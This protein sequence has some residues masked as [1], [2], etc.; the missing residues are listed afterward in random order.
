MPQHPNP[1]RSR[2]LLRPWLG[3]G[4]GDDETRAA[5]ALPS[6]AG[7]SSGTSAADSHFTT[8]SARAPL[9][10]VLIEER[11][12]TRLRGGDVALHLF[13]PVDYRIQSLFG[14]IKRLPRECLRLVEAEIRPTA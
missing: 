13:V 1:L 4:W 2:R 8:S 12:R 9:G 5:T 3:S 14:L 10:D 11:L 6:S 7:W